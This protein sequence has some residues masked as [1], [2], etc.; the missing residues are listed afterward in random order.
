MFD[1]DDTEA[2]HLSEIYDD[3]EIESR[4]Y[5]LSERKDYISAKGRCFR[6]KDIG[7]YVVVQ[8]PRNKRV[9]SKMFLVDR[10][11]TKRFWWSPDSYY[12]MIFEKKEAAELQAKKYKYNNVRVK[13]ITKDMAYIKWFNKVYELGGF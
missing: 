12:A 11:I 7:K 2:A 5:S 6:D 3:C 4:S 9:M 13:Q 1:F 10:K 8:T